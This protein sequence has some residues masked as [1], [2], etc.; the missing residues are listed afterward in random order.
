MF[1]CYD[2]VM[3]QQWLIF[4]TGV[5]VFFLPL[6]GFPRAFNTFVYMLSGL[7]LMALSLRAIR[8]QYVKDLYDKDKSS[9]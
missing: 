1:L 5:A 9:G 8:K 4:G 2:M 6:L 7:V 3:R